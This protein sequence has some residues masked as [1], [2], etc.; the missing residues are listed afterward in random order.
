M[1]WHEVNKADHY[2]ISVDA[3]GQALPV[4]EGARE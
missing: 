1:P 3:A 2:W 4:R